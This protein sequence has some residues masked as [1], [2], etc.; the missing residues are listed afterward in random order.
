MSCLMNVTLSVSVTK[1]QVEKRLHIP[2]AWFLCDGCGR[3]ACPIRYN[4]IS[5]SFIYNYICL[6]LGLVIEQNWFGQRVPCASTLAAWRRLSFLATSGEN[7]RKELDVAFYVEQCYATPQKICRKE[8]L[9]RLHS[10]C[11]IRDV[12]F[13]RLVYF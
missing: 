2:G 13:W 5:I 12:G 4:Q 7:S 10:V 9:H 3:G 1:H 11:C 6:A 8:R